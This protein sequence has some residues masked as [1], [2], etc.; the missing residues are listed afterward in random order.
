MK[1]PPSANVCI[2]WS[3]PAVGAIVL[4][5]S[6]IHLY[7]LNHNT[8]RQNENKK[9]TVAFVLSIFD[10]HFNNSNNTNQ[11]RYM[12]VWLEVVK[13]YVFH[14]CFNFPVNTMIQVQYCIALY[15]YIL[16]VLGSAFSATTALFQN[17]LLLWTS[18]ILDDAVS[19]AISD[20]DT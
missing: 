15:W 13:Q 16:V 8:C 20:T 19:I 7:N 5:T 2:F 9:S 11:Q 14:I 4:R 12:F 3:R 17:R 1:W 6:C 10:K 18:T